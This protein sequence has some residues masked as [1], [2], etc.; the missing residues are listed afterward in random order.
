MGSALRAIGRPIIYSLSNYGMDR[1]WE[2]APTTGAQLW[3]TSGDI[4]ARYETILAI[5]FGQEGW[6]ASRAMAIG[7]ILTC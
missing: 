6:S 1:I 5:G 7:T 3:R 2:W 4:Q